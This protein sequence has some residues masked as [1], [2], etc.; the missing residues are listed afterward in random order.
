MVEKVSHDNT[1][2]LALVIV[3]LASSLRAS[4]ERQ[5][6]TYYLFSISISID[7]SSRKA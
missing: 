6:I 7:S 2:V 3:F 4:H 1:I 5:S